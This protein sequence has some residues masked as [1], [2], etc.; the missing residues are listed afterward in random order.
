MKKN[1]F[2]LFIVCFVMC[3]F[4]KIEVVTT[5]PY[6]S[7]LVQKIGKEKVNSMSL[8]G[9]SW[10]PHTIVPRPSLIAKVRN[11]DLLIINGAQLE[12]G[13]LPPLLNQANNPEV[14]PGKKGF[15][16]L[17]NYVQ[18][19]QVPTSVSRAQGD[20][21]PEGNPHFNLGPTNIP[22]LS[23][24]IA[25][26]LGQLDAAN[27]QY[28]RDNNQIF[29]QQWDARLQ[30]WSRRMES[31]R[32]SKYIEYHRNLDYFLE[33]Y[34]LIV[35]E[36]I[37]PLPGIPPTSKHILELIDK[38]ES[39]QIKFILHDVYHSRKSSRYF[40]RK[41]GIPFVIIPHDVGAV[42]EA[43]DIFSLFEEILRR[44]GV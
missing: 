39:D 18:L 6:M 33:H 2:M 44:L 30:E 34:H 16:D 1:L 14:M 26:K 8:T 4:A 3:S 41:T 32:G 13:W 23:S 40:S 19:I 10:D 11:A 20:I 15:L 36:T 21:H 31:L 25:E 29:S 35:V 43:T 12:I 5:Y 28:Y 37:E 7:D 24:A 22:K 9:G 27:A 17:S 38:T 42:K